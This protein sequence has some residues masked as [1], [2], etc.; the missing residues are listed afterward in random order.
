M[1][2]ADAEALLTFAD[3]ADTIGPFQ[4]APGIMN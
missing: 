1:I 3:C 2:Q 4:N